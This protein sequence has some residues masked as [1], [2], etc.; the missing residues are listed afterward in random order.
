MKQAHEDFGRRE[1]AMFPPLKS[2]GLIEAFYWINE[3][4][5]IFLFP[6]LKSGG[7]IEARRSWP[8]TCLPQMFPPLKSGGLIEACDRGLFGSGMRC[9][10]R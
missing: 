8:Q 2:G 1:T 4:H 10:L 3:R 9:F 7:L 5:S 6:P